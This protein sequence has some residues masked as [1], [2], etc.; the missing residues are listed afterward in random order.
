M[1]IVF[2]ACNNEKKGLSARFTFSKVIRD[3]GRSS[4]VLEENAGRDLALCSE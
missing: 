4:A 1:G 3:F 2:K